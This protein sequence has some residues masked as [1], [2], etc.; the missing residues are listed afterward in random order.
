MLNIMKK[1]ILSLSVIFSSLSLI[2]QDGDPH[3]I[4]GVWKSP[5]RELMIKI[6]QIGDHFQGRIVWIQSSNSNQPALDIHNPDER[7]QKVPLKGNKV[8]QELSFN[9]AKTVW[10][11]GTF[12]NY[13][14]GKLYN[15]L[16]TLQS[17]DKIKITRY[18]NNQQDGIDETWERQ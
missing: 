16:I 10:E 2:S 14:E 12:Y 15:C 6:D 11:G 7:L 8:I 9:D 3:K 18:L 17:D 4:L 1:Y 5:S 13:E